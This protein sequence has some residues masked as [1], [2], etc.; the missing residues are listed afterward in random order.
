MIIKDFQLSSSDLQALWDPKL[1]I[2]NLEKRHK[3]VNETDWGFKMEN[4]KPTVFH[5]IRVKGSFY[6]NMELEHFPRDVQ[7]IYFSRVAQLCQQLKL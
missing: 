3:D 2:N 6:E 5:S 4:G 7:V 1:Q